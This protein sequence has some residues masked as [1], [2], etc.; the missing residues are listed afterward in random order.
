MPQPELFA[1]PLEPVVRD[2]TRERIHAAM[3]ARVDRLLNRV[4]NEPFVQT[5][6]GLYIRDFNEQL[7]GPN[8]EFRG[9]SAVLM[10][11]EELFNQD[12]RDYL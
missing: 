8:D 1:K 4:E 6:S 12:V 9:D 5:I 3:R 10:I 11:V 2:L 7:Y